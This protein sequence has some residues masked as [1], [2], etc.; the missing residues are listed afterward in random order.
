MS[1]SL[2]LNKAVKNIR[3]ETD[4]VISGTLAQLSVNIIKDTPVGNPSLWAPQS[5]PAPEGYVGGSLRGAWNAS[6]GSPDRAKTNRIEN[7]DGGGSTAA[8]AASIASSYKAG[9]AFYLTN[10]LPYSRRVELGWST[11][12]PE[13]MLRLNVMRAQQVLD[14]V[15]KR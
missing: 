1:F 12:A 6:F 3:E 15:A 11:Q 2:D 8:D 5:L 9:Q 10:P 13:G 7:N 14:K 4:R